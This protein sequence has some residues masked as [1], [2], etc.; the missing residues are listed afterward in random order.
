MT[1]R[2]FRDP[3][4]SEAIESIDENFFVAAGAG[5]GKTRVLVE[6]YL[7]LLRA[8]RAGVYGIAAVTYTEKA[9]KEMKDR[10]RQACVEEEAACGD[11]V[12]RAFWHEQRIALE[13]GHIGTI[14]SLC[15]SILRL[16]PVEAHVDPQF[17][18][19][20]EAKADVLRRKTTDEALGRLLD[21]GDR[22][23]IELIRQFG[24]DDVVT[25][26][27]AMLRKR[28]R[29]EVAA[30]VTARGTV[31]QLVEEFVSAQTGRAAQAVNALLASEDWRRALATLA[32]LKALDSGDKLET[33]RQELVRLSTEVNRAAETN[34]RLALLGRL[35]AAV[36]LRVGSKRSW[37][38]EEMRRV[39]EAAGRLRECVRSLPEIPDE[40]A[41]AALRREFAASRSLITVYHAVNR[42][43]EAAKAERGFLDFDDLLMKTRT[44]LVG[45]GDGRRRLQRKF[46]YMMVDELQD[47]SFLERDIVVLLCQANVGDDP[48][49][50]RLVPGKLFVVG[51]DKQSIYGFRGAEVTVFGDFRD[52]I[53]QC[54]RLTELDRNY[55]TTAEGVAFANALFAGLL[56]ERVGRKDYESVYHPL[57]AHRKPGGTFVEI[58]AAPMAKDAQM[59]ERRQAEAALLAERIEAMVKDPELTA[60]KPD[61]TVGRVEY[62]D[63]AVLFRALTQAHTYED[64]L[65]DA[66]IPYYLI[67][68]SGFYAAQEVRDVL[69]CLKALERRSD[70][71]ALVGALRSPMFG[72]SDDVLYC[73]SRS[74]DLVDALLHP[75]TMQGV[76]E[77]QRA[78]VK[79]AGEVLYSLWAEKNRLGVAE[80]V[81]RL[82]VRTGFDGAVLGQF[83]GLQKLANLE[84]LIDDARDFESSGIF[85]LDDFIQYMDEFVQ[86]EA[87]ESERSAVEEKSNVVRLMSIH[88]AKGL[89][90]PVVF[91]ADMARSRTPFG[92]ALLADRELGLA[93]RL[94]HSSR[95]GKE[96]RPL[97][98]LLS[99]EARRREE[100]EERRLL[101]VAVTRACDRLVLC[102]SFCQETHE[103]NWLTLVAGALGIDEIPSE[104]GTFTYGDGFAGII[105]TRPTGAGVSHETQ[106]ALAGWLGVQR[107]DKVMGTSEP[108]PLADELRTRVEP[109]T[110]DWARKRRFSVSELLS[111]RSCPR[112]YYCRYVL[113]LAH[114]SSIAPAAA[115]R[116]MGALIGSVVHRVLALW[117]LKDLAALPD[118]AGQAARELKS[119]SGRDAR[120]AAEQAQALLAGAHRQNLL[121]DLTD[122]GSAFTEWPFCMALDGSLVEGII[123]RLYVRPD[124]VRRIVDYKTNRV[125]TEDAE[126]LAEHYRFQVM[127]YALAAGEAG[128]PIGQASV[129]FLSPGK[130][131][132]WDLSEVDLE[133]LRGELLVVMRSIQSGRFEPATRQ[134]CRCG[135][136]YLCPDTKGIAGH[137]AQLEP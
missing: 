122:A 112:Q 84:K 24:R 58:L 111:Y 45:D 78:Q 113:K 47:T 116:T 55:R 89:E 136:R 8:R 51:D 133:A 75:E 100:A 39:K 36:N 73:M 7:Q 43:Y 13:N 2:P 81:R 125:G 137:E 28:Y 106:A 82:L 33:M 124:G 128:L 88:K 37:H 98:K 105:R 20:D 118:L 40:E 103:E 135:Y 14:H 65:R 46:R 15:S 38:E 68:G 77:G 114:E 48:G 117:D 30:A 64:A 85:T 101:Y 74:G 102:G 96:L 83:M 127:A 32:G 94:P 108:A 3:R 104:G 29:T 67:A 23:L 66:G 76:T 119:V 91:L 130:W 16:C 25:F 60:R 69:N 18:V 121:A 80:L 86:N 54:G 56:A 10:I 1:E 9:A 134:A 5:T 31:E 50:A 27:D 109:L 70:R 92:Q 115:G 42:A 17:G 87:R 90:F 71:I 95:K 63:I 99:A 93:V 57:A 129:L 44:F 35:G 21:E 79:R 72:L 131:V 61:G 110:P 12:S 22:D 34:E 132:R 4:Q 62:G 6:R 126:V 49:Q 123:D 97:H 19:L 11:E 53:G 59:D 120:I 26:L 52:R 107:L 41:I